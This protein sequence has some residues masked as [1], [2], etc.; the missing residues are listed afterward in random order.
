M[1]SPNVL[2]PYCP[3]RQVLEMLANKW[4]L[5]V[6][7]TLAQGT[8][9]YSQI[10]RESGGVTQKM[11]TQTLRE[12]EE[13]GIVQRVV[14]PVIPP[15]VEYSLTPLGESLIEPLNAICRW[16]EQNFAEIAQA[17]A[18][19]AEKKEQSGGSLTR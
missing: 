16:A 4:T 18:A 1:L 3:S 10:Q 19:Y 11:L 5:L 17:R 9:R 12:L 6:V 2:N 15:K 8:R 14:Y 7:R 13:N